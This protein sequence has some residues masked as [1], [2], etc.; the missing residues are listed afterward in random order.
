MGMRTA[1]DP[2]E[3]T[4]WIMVAFGIVVSVMQGWDC[5]QRYLAQP[6]SIEEEVVSISDLPPIQ[7]S[8]CKIFD[9]KGLNHEK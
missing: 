4:T 8:I 6:I 3:M 2:Y 9:L 5:T 7:L 1:W